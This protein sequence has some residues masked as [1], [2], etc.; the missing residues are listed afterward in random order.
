MAGAPKFLR[1]LVLVAAALLIVALAACGSDDD[2][3]AGEDD[4][5]P[6]ARPAD[7]PDPKGKTLEQLRSEL[8]P[9]GPVLA[10][11]VS[12]LEAGGE[13][14]LGFGLFERSR[15]QITQAKTAL[16]VSDRKGQTV[17]GPYPAE[18][19]SLDV[20]EPFQS[21]SVKSDPDSAESLYVAD[22][23]F[24]KS[25]DYIVLAALELD[26]RLVAADPAAVR[27]VK[28]ANTP[29]V[30][31]PAP[32]VSTPTT[33]EVKDIAAIDTRVP[34]S[35]DLHED[36]LADVIGKKPVVLLF[37]TP[38]LCQSRVCGPV[39]D[40]MKQVKEAHSDEDI[41]WIHME[42]FKDNEFDKGFREQV[43]AWKLPTEPWLF[44]I[45]ADGRVAARLE[46]AFGEDELEE[47][48]AAAT[49]N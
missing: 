36:D 38:A 23:P 16:Y 10:P 26:G 13:S 48:V 3:G 25:G 41:S 29:E 22:V 37:A 17:R 45:G 32:S 21:D 1:L 27:V 11:S 46:G 9:G 14:R 49:K 31:E 20:E 2:E 5:P 15:K 39:V 7:F 43:L 18:F 6:V 28:D 34:P 12:L 33:A 47:A 30:G 44:T 19:K 42:I 8:G 4:S 35:P 40:I 24:E